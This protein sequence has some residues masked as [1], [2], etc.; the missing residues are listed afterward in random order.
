MS[1]RTSCIILAIVFLVAGLQHSDGHAAP[2]RPA[3]GV[4]APPVTSSAA[5]PSPHTSV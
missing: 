2:Y 4:P 1:F 5:T 3:S